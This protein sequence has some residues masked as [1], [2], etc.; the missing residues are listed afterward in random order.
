MSYKMFDIPPPILRNTNMKVK[1][2]QEV[3]GKGLMGIIED[4]R[5]GLKLIIE[6]G[7]R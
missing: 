7:V 5:F 4:D 2:M 6:I 3:P 1:S